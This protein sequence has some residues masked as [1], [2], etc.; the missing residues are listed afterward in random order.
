MNR[1]VILPVLLAVAACAGAAARVPQEVP[2]PG[3][4]RVDLDSKMEE[5]VGQ[6]AYAIHSRTDGGSGDESTRS[7]AAG[8][9]SGTRV[10]KGSAPLTQCIKAGP[11]ALPSHLAK[12]VCKTL[13]TS[14]T[15]EGLVQ[16]ASCPS[17][18]L[19]LRIRRLDDKTWEYLTDTDMS[20][21]TTPKLDGTRT[22]LEMA[23]HGA[24]TAA[25]RAEAKKALAGLPRA[26]AQMDQE[27]VKAE[28][29]LQ[30]ALAAAR[31]PQEAALVRQ[32]MARIHGQVPIQIRARTTLTR[33]ADHC[34]AS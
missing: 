4:Y 16:V 9:D 22:M 6:H 21:G 15:A 18:K 24:S 3:L 33:I 31:T 34:S 32:A 23:A 2:P 20:S 5:K 7:V 25:E 28:A 14:R 10:A 12:G 30:Q 13:S 19:T 27:R 11:P 17:G 29:A 1:L 26:Q 8:Q